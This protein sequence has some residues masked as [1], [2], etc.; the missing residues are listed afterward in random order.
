MLQTKYIETLLRRFKLEDCKPVATPMEIGL[1]LS[2]HDFGDYLD[3]CCLPAGYEMPYL[4]MH[5]DT[6]HLVCSFTSE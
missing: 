2:I 6:R 4:Y 1:H 5:C 3:S